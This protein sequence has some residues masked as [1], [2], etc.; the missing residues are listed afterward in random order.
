MLDTHNHYRYILQ[1]L[2]KEQLETLRCS[3]LQGR[4]RVPAAMDLA[5]MTQVQLAEKTGYTQ[6]TVSRV[7]NGRYSDLPGETMRKFAEVFG[8]AIEDLFPARE[9]V[10][11]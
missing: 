3:Q 10:A 4:N 2:S 1:V 11:S 8:C 5:G 7:R 9:E 6:P